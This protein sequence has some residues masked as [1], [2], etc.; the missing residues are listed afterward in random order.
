MQDQQDQSMPQ[1]QPWQALQGN[2]EKA[3]EIFSKRIK[4]FK[5]S[6][7][8]DLF[9]S[10]TIGGMLFKSKFI[11]ISPK[12]E[13]HSMASLSEASSNGESSRLKREN[14]VSL[15]E[16]NESADRMSHKLNPKQQLA[17]T[18]KNWSAIPAND[19]HLIAEGG[20]EALVAL[21]SVEDFKIKKSC[22][23]TYIYT[24]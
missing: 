9:G 8:G 12:Q 1:T 2:S 23:G 14:T 24:I 6:I 16:D 19:A 5:K 4:I 11:G 20:I 22:A 7:C 17:I 10:S 18:L 21:S 13:A 15:E 3:K